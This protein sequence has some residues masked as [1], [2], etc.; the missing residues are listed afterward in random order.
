MKSST[1]GQN[2]TL[3][4]TTRTNK[5]RITAD[6]RALGRPGAYVNSVGGQ[7]PS[8][9]LRE[10]FSKIRMRCLFRVLSVVAGHVALP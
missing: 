9:R 6:P 5:G 2:I 4:P 1:I 8:V 7:T 10:W 3:R